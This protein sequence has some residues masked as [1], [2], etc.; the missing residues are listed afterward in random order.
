MSG[1]ANLQVPD[2]PVDALRVPSIPLPFFQPIKIYEATR[3]IPI[4][5]IRMF[6]H[7]VLLGKELGPQEDVTYGPG[8]VRKEHKL[9]GTCTLLQNIGSR[10]TGVGQARFLFSYPPPATAP[11]GTP[12]EDFIFLFVYP[13]LARM[14]HWTKAEDVWD[15]E[16][17]TICDMAERSLRQFPADPFITP[18]PVPRPDITF[19]SREKGIAGSGRLEIGEGVTAFCYYS[20]FKVG[21]HSKLQPGRIGTI[22]QLYPWLSI[23]TTLSDR[24]IEAE[25]QAAKESYER[26][27]SEDF[28]KIYLVDLARFQMRLFSLYTQHKELTHHIIGSLARR[29]PGAGTNVLRGTTA[30]HHL[31]HRPVENVWD[32]LC[33]RAIALRK[34]AEQ[35]ADI[36]PTEPKL[37]L[38][39]PSE[40][41]A[42]SSDPVRDL[43]DPLVRYQPSVIGSVTSCFSRDAQSRPDSRQ[44]WYD[45]AVVEIETIPANEAEGLSPDDRF[46]SAEV[47]PG[48]LEDNVQK[49][50]DNAGATV[51]MMKDLVKIV[52]RLRDLQ[53]KVRAQDGKELTEMESITVFPQ[54]AAEWQKQIPALLLID[55]ANGKLMNVG[56]WSYRSYMV[57]IWRLAFTPHFLWGA[58]D[59][60]MTARGFY[61]QEMANL[62]GDLNNF[63]GD[64]KRI[65]QDVWPKVFKGAKWESGKK[66]TH[67]DLFTMIQMD[68]DLFL[69]GCE[70][71][72]HAGIVQFANAYTPGKAPYFTGKMEKLGK[73]YQVIHD[74]ADL[75]DTDAIPIIDTK[76]LAYGVRLDA[77][78]MYHW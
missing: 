30:I 16:H 11:Q 65:M 27:K 44:G 24:P 14:Y 76:K 34:E 74:L 62:T 54:P 68:L 12:S 70:H 40:S 3:G 25:R 36:L 60:E 32:W 45:P 48:K 59:T 15:S 39:G 6:V 2:A 69:V 58:G 42:V 72:A 56:D 73:W 63:K 17:Q 52:N 7:D 57:P 26:L 13:Y 47:R 9:S 71:A 55:D 66:L 64:D 75:M 22:R 5:P 49:D 41:S 4:Y 29:P 37:V 61:W 21:S 43:T 78:W 50:I 38:S 1:N 35:K 77:K 51:E 23:D 20:L 19:K 46:P 8:V 28:Q 10:F 33:Y 18:Y 31:T 53:N 67:D